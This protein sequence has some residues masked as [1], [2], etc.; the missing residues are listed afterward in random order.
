VIDTWEGNEGR[1]SSMGTYGIFIM[2]IS[3]NKKSNN[4]PTQMSSP[5]IG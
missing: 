1:E 2:L 5:A 3:L 4:N